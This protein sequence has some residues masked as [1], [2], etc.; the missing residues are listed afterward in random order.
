MTFFDRVRAEPLPYHEQ[1]GALQLCRCL[2]RLLLRLPLPLPL[3][4][5]RLRHSSLH[6]GRLQPVIA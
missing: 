3:S 5:Q 1:G 4:H 2:L 6:L